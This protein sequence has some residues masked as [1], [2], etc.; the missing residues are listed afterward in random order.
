[1]A[2]SLFGGVL[3]LPGGK[4]NST[5]AARPWHLANSRMTILASSLRRRLG[6]GVSVNQVRYRLRGWNAPTLDAVTDAS[7]ALVRMS[8]K[9]DPAQI[10]VVGHSMGGRVA[11]HLSATGEAGAVVALAPWWP[12]NDAELIP[13]GCRLLVIH[14]TADTWTNPGSSR[15]QT[16]LA[17]GRGV[18]AQWIGMRG[19]GHYL[20]RD[21]DRWHR[22]TAEFIGTQLAQ[23]LSDP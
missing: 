11:A 8:E 6:P 17:R 5:I 12:H 10:V 2:P 20:L 3:V 15:A 14:G 16:D 13:V 19:A 21:W 18:D 7:A 1:M 9:L 23:S 4:P 22:L